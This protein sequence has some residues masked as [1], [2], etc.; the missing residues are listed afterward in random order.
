MYGADTVVQHPVPLVASKAAA[1]FEWVDHD[2]P[3]VQHGS[4]S[5]AQTACSQWRPVQ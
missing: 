1:A 2:W 3:C 5:V 4:G